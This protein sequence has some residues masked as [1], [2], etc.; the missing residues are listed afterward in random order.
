MGVWAEM[1]E[2]VDHFSTAEVNLWLAL[3][4]L[5]TPVPLAGRHSKLKCGSHAIVDIRPLSGVLKSVWACCWM[6]I[7]LLNTGTAC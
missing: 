2:G 1:L 6:A 7:L 3:T 5:E 4:T